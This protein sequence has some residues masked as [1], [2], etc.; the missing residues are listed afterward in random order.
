MLAIFAGAVVTFALAKPLTFFLA[1]VD[2][3]VG[4]TAATI[5]LGIGAY[6]YGLISG[7]LLFQRLRVP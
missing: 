6:V 3:G 5:S 2:Y 4:M 7:P 1:E